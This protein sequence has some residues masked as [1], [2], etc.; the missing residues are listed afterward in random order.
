MKNYTV[1]V[2]AEYTKAG[3]APADRFSVQ[4]S[5]M[6]VAAKRAADRVRGNAELGRAKYLNLRLIEVA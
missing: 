4:A 3:Y 2:E 1:L 6:S 5:S